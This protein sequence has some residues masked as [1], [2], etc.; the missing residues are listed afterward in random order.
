MRTLVTWVA[1]SSRSFGKALGKVFYFFNRWPKVSVLVSH[2]AINSEIFCNLKFSR[3]KIIRNLFASA[4]KEKPSQVFECFIFKRY[5]FDSDLL[6]FKLK[7]QLQLESLL[8]RG[9]DSELFWRNMLA[10]VGLGFSEKVSKSLKKLDAVLLNEGL[11]RTC[12]DAWWDKALITIIH[13]Y[14]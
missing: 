7:F 3:S 1:N 2:V 6:F 5:F 10:L 8:V 9:S 14:M 12:G 4:L 13:K 11:L